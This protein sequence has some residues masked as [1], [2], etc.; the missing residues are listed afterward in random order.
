MSWPRLFVV[1][2]MWLRPSLAR[3]VA[4]SYAR[5][6]DDEPERLP[7]TSHQIPAKSAPPPMT[8]TDEEIVARICAGEQEL[9]ELLMRRHNPR[10]YR[11][12]RAILHN[13]AETEDVMLDAYGLAYEHLRELE[14]R[15]RFSRWLTRIAVHEA[16]A[17]VRR[18][19]RFDSLDSCADDRSMSAAS[20]C[21][22][23]QQTSDAEMRCLIE[24]A[25]GALPEEF[26]SVFVLRA[27]HGMRTA[28][29]A[30]YLGLTVATVKTRLFRA[31]GRLQDLLVASGRFPGFRRK[32]DSDR[33][34]R[35]TVLPAR[36]VARAGSWGG[37]SRSQLNEPGCPPSS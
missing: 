27:V 32:T 9:F 29:V 5:R 31:R 2:E 13:D 36:A 34:A 37:S 1:D 4:V 8:L 7:D 35:P 33:A 10:V 18:S 14:G 6:D 26:R 11:A 23:E 17:R 28:E 16:L 15:A 12:A 20:A 30:G 25:I 24:K 21:S 3:M 22:P 19:K